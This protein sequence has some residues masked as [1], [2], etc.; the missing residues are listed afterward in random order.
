MS[1][2]LMN[3]LAYLA[4]LALIGMIA[5]T[6][7][8]C[9]TV[10]A[11]VRKVKSTSSLIAP[12]RNSVDQI[13]K[14]CKGIYVRSK[15]RAISMASHANAAAGS[16]TSARDEIAAVADTIDIDG[17]QGAAREAADTLRH[18]SA[19]ANIIDQILKVIR[20]AGSASSG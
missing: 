12:P 15:N 17:I 5:I 8:G 4:V 10:L 2:I 6:I 1:L 13:V 9:L 18:G 20:S 16:V 7:W 11:M 14:I 3:I 19:A